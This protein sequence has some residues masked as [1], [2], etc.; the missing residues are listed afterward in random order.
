MKFNPDIIKSDRRTVSIE[1]RPDGKVTLHVP[2]RMTY[3]EIEKLI[4]E[5]S[6]WI[7]KTIAKYNSAL[8]DEIVPYTDEELDEMTAI[9][10]RIIPPRVEY[11][12]KLMGVTYGKITIRHPKTR[13]GSCTSKG[14]L[15]FN[16]LLTQVPP[17]ILDS[18]VVHEL[19]HRREMNHSERFYAQ[20]LNV[21][22]DY[23][24][25]DRW[26]RQNG[27]KLMARI[28]KTTEEKEEER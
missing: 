15:S 19:S 9:A 13:W 5:K 4:E 27:M 28:R 16:C 14:N 25:R 1:V 8:G 22:P 6:P 11:Y 2:K 12:A 17:E 26:L 7:E 21:M 3:R 23:H 18:V 10:K 24:E 20:I